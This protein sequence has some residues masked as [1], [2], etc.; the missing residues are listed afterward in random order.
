MNHADSMRQFNYFG[1]N[2]GMAHH[3]GIDEDV[4]LL[5]REIETVMMNSANKGGT[6]VG[7]KRDRI[8]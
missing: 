8:D 4:E 6:A 3:A 5:E 7:G 1:S 2:P